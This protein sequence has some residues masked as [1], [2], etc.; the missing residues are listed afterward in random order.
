MMLFF[1]F[2]KCTK[3]KGFFTKRHHFLMKGHCEIKKKSAVLKGD[4]YRVLNLR[5]I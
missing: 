1:V 2:A 4:N 3:P 5:F